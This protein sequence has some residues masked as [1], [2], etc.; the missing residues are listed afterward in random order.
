MNLSARISKLDRI[1]LFW[2]SSHTQREP[3]YQPAIR[4]MRGI[5]HLEKGFRVTILRYSRSYVS[6]LMSEKPTIIAGLLVVWLF[7]FL[8]FLNLGI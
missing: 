4:A 6:E 2:L 8:F 3:D 7:W 5:G 1:G